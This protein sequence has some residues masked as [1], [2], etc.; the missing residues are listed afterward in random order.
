MTKSVS[1]AT[2]H[3]LRHKRSSALKPW[4]RKRKEDFGEWLKKKTNATT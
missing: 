3:A 2:R 1:S 4:A